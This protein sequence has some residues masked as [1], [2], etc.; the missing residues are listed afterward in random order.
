MTALGRRSTSAAGHCR[1]WQLF[2]QPAWSSEL[3]HCHQH[4][5]QMV[6][7]SRPGP[8]PSSFER[9]MVVLAVSIIAEEQEQMVALLAFA[10]ASTVFGTV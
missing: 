10:E 5:C 3:Q 6:L 8:A 2:A 7:A 4:S 1:C 9:I